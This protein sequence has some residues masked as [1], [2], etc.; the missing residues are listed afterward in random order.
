M[1]AFDLP[2]RLRPFSATLSA[3]RSSPSPPAP[4]QRTA[5]RLHAVQIMHRTK[6]VH[7][8]QHRLDAAGLGFESLKAQQ[9]IEPDQATAG[10]MQ[11]VDLE[12][13]AV[14]GVALEA[15]GDQEHDRAAAE[16]AARPLLVEG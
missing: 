11:A 2:Q 8:G 16:H 4:R 12:G 5:Q 6:L 10:A 7:V 1:T 14:V 3:P 15:V 13:E 9:W